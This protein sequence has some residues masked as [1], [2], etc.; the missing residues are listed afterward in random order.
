MMTPVYNATYLSKTAKSVGNMLHDAVI[1]FGYKGDEFLHMFIQSGI[2]EEIESG[3][4]K[5]IAG[6]SGIELFS[7][8][9]ERTVGKQIDADVIETYEKSDVY[10][11]GWALTHYQWYS[12]RSFKDILETVSFD[13]LQGLYDTLHETDVRKFYEVLD[14]HFAQTG[15][16]LKIVRKDCGLTQEELSGLSGV[17]INTI[18]AYERKSK[19]INKAQ[20]EIVV[21]LSGALKC[22][23]MDI[24]G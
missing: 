16:K 20:A 3:N 13:A 18:R 24:L 5:Y 1:E 22:E 6:K 2:A 15:S 11:I 21:R 8:V 12:G 14:A 19:D 10:W 7:E 17:S 4:P 23:M 9:M